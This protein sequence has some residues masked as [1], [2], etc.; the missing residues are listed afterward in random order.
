MAEAG[1][2][3][4]ARRSPMADNICAP[5]HHVAA[6]AAAPGRALRRLSGPAHPAASL[7]RG[8]AAPGAGLYDEELVRPGSAVGTQIQSS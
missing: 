8:R 7:P 4:R 6:A 1:A 5:G 2:P 3:R